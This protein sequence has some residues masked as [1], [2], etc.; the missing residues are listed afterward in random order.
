MLLAIDLKVLHFK[1]CFTVQRTVASILK[2]WLSHYKPLEK[3]Y[4][5]SLSDPK[6]NI[7]HELSLLIPVIPLQQIYKLMGLL[8]RVK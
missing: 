8:L 5:T 1:C 6:K 2:T 7:R 3:P 4:T